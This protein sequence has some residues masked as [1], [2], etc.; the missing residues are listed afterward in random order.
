EALGASAR[1]PP[2]LQPRH[3]AAHPHRPAARAHP[4]HQ[5]GNPH[6]HLVATTSNADCT[7]LTAP[8]HT[9]PHT[10]TT[11][12]HIQ[13][14]HL[15]PLGDLYDKCQETLIQYT[16]FLQTNVTPA[17]R[18]AALFPPLRDLVT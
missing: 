15:K 2:Q 12:T 6:H 7:R 16:E 9:P 1:G 5:Q 3:L 4:L 18:Y 17:T 10:P 13:A 11:T 8:P 14:S